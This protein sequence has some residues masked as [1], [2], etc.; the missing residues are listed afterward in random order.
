MSEA[1]ER[2]YAEEL[3]SWITISREVA[4][5]YV[6][7]L[8]QQLSEL[9]ESRKQKQIIRLCNRLDK[10]EQQNKQML[11]CLILIYTEHDPI[12]YPAILA[13]E[14]VESVTENQSTRQQNDVLQR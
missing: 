4:H 3:E 10:A 9:K 2:Y 7:E 1:R 12:Y 11:E 13:R 6:T 14:C 5:D 8:E